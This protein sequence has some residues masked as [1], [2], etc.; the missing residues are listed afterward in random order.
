MQLSKHFSLAEMTHSQNAARMSIDNNP[1]ETLLNALKATAEGMEQVRKLLGDKPIVISSGY[2]S[3]ALNAVV[4]GAK[5]SQ[6]CLGEA[7]DFTCPAFGNPQDVMK[8][9]AGS[10][11]AYDQVI[12][13]FYSSSGNGWTHISF[14]PRNR[15]NALIVDST[16]TRVWV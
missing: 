8:A 16:G 10:K 14:G 6:H 2:R 11:I 13:E 7:V 9:I 4:R 3:P 15:R 5:G 12:L 1:P